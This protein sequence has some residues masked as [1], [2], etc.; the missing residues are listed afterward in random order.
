MASGTTYDFLSLVAPLHFWGSLWIVAGAVLLV[1]AFKVKDRVGFAVAIF[2]KIL[3]GSMFFAAWVF[4]DVDRGY[5]SAA[6]WL[7][8]AGVVAIVATWPDEWKDTVMSRDAQ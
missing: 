7:S 6:I 5:L 2:I 8:F 4:A 1:F 3:W